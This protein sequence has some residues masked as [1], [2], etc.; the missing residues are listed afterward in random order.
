MEDG[1]QILNVLRPLPEI[2]IALEG[3]VPLGHSSWLAG[4]APAIRVIGDTRYTQKVLIDGKEAT[5]GVDGTC[6]A[7]GWDEPGHH[8]VWCSNM[9]RS[10]SLIRREGPWDAWPAY[11][12]HSPSG[13]DRVAICGPLVRPLSTDDNLREV[14]HRPEVENNPVLLGPIPGQVFV[15]VPRQDVRGAYSFASPPFD[16]VWAL[17]LQPLRCDKTSQRIL[18][19]GDSRAPENGV[20]PFS[21][22]RGSVLQWYRLILDASRKGLLVEPLAARDLWLSYR[23]FARSL[24]RPAVRCRR[25]KRANP[26]AQE[27]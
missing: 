26:P 1:P 10:Y 9:S 11:V 24:R 27:G 4:C 23:R 19:V 5:I 16:P 6:C 22:S 2:D 12:Y 3:G 21:T 20:A 25:H 7:P 15:A 8:Q 18:L 13:G 17:P 14:G